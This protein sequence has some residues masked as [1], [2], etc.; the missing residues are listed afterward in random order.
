[1]DGVHVEGEERLAGEKTVRMRISYRVEDK[2]YHSL[3]FA[4]E[5]TEQQRS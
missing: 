2:G 5:D 1:M 4:D 3:Q